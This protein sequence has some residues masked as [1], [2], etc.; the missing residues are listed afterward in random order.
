M[1]PFSEDNLI[2]KTVIKII[3]EIWGGSA[4]H[5]NGY[6]DENDLL[7]DRE[8]RG[9]VVLQKY[10]LQ[11]LKKINPDLP[12]IALAQAIDAI[13]RDRSNLSLVKANQEIYK[14]LRD[15]VNVDVAGED[16]ETSPPSHSYG[17]TRT[18]RVSFFDFQNIENNNFLA[19]SQLWIA[20]EMYTRRPDVIL[21]ANGIP[22][23][24][25][26]LKAAHKNLA[27]AYRD[28]IRDYKDTIPKLFWYN[29]GII[30]SNGIENKFGSLTAPYE[31]FNEWKKAENEEEEPK[32]DLAAMLRGVCDKKRLLD[33]F[34]NFILLDASKAEI[35]KIVPRYFQY[36]GVNRAFD[37]VAHRKERDGKLGVFWH[38]QGSGKSYSMIW[39][40]EKVLRKMAGNFTFIIVT[41]RT[42]LDR[43][44]YDN[45]ANVGAIH[46]AETHAETIDHLKELLAQ[47][48]RQ[49]FTTIQ[50]FQNIA[51]AISSRE[52]I[53]VMT[54]EAHRSQYD[55]MALNM[56]K[57]LPNASFIG[58][59]GTP[60][61]AD[62]EAET[63]KT[64][65][66]Y[67]S[68]YNFGQSVADG[69]TVPLYYE[70]RVPRLKNVNED[71]EEQLGQLMDKYNLE[72][73]EEEKLE[74][75]Y[76]NFYEIITREDRLN[77]IARD[78]VAHYA[79]R[80][81][82][83]KAMVVC[84]DK[85]TAF[86]M[87]DKVKKEWDRYVAKLRMDL[88]RAKDERKQEKILAKLAQHENVDMAV[89]VSLGDNQNEIADMEE[90]EIDVRPIR[91]R[92]IKG[93][94]EEEFKKAD[95][96]LRII[97]V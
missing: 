54:D 56:R 27:D 34:E 78:I 38:T 10:L 19:V 17:E 21:F 92:I 88:S 87:Y 76:S 67:V 83:G 48:H 95:G 51:G 33:I 12:A 79:G 5:I 32:T 15:G 75:E 60:L 71:L 49:I 74:R 1:N 18:E 39:L 59:T 2:E 43:Q 80:G 45:F 4:C 6:N 50:K 62:G 55:T 64:F 63:V 93:N 8:N 85:K 72:E 46:E 82:N 26:E 73:D 25:L 69:A 77:T 47:D 11:A 65:G 86:R 16:G 61:M 37:N 96:N 7:L 14:L 42:Q 31:F 23:V 35:K 20:G 22:L 57:A 44:A 84:I 66:D 41:D 9:E 53:I 40:S 68:V 28:N 90:F 29:M 13:T 52:D 81:Y 24:L 30:I 97:C 89:M 91:E 58:F 36:L 3:K 70:N 94:L